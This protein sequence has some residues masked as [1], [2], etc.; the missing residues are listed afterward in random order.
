VQGGHIHSASTD[1]TEDV[2]KK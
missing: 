2:Q 1:I